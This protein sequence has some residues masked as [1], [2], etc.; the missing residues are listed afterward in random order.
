M[1]TLTVL[2]GIPG[3]GK[4]TFAATWTTGRVVSADDVRLEGAAGAATLARL[5]RQARRLLVAGH[6]VTVDA[7]STQAPRRVEWLALAA[8]LDVPT[9][10]ILFPV[11]ADVAQKR[12]ATRPR[13][14]RVPWPAV[15]KYIR[16]WPAAVAAARAEPWGEVID[17]TAVRVTSGVW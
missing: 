6:D 11:A 9:R 3:S 7:C 15:Q 8:E 5:H 16:Q 4:S 13:D 1:S 17:A 12:N 14:E 10:L 2:M